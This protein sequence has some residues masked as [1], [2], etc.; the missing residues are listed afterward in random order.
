MANILNYITDCQHENFYETPLN[1]LDILALTEVSYL[2][3]DDLIC[4]DFSAE[5]G[6]RLDDL[7]TQF[8]E[9]FKMGYPPLSMVNRDR[10]ALLQSLSTSKRFKY[11]RAFA[12]INDYS[13]EAQKQFAAVCYRI[14]PQNVLTVFR[15]TDD[16]IIGWKEDFHMTY[17]AE[18]PAQAA[19]RDYLETAIEKLTTNFYVSGHSKGGN[20]AIFASSQVKTALQESIQDVYSF[21][22]PGLHDSILQSN[23]YSAIENRIHSIIP[24]GSIVGMMLETPRNALIVKSTGLGL[25]QHVSFTWEIANR[26]FLPAPSLTTESLQMDQTLK[27]WTASLTPEEL[28]TF[29]DLFFGLFTQAGI[30][31]FSDITVDTPTKLQAL[32]KNR[33]LLTPEENQMFERITHLLIDTRYQIWKDQLQPLPNFDMKKLK[34][35]LP[36]FHQS[37]SKLTEEFSDE[38]NKQK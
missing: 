38:K 9:K 16:T 35:N 10:L 34:I 12:Y 31:R 18:I 19:A 29:F 17:M 32:A 15:G 25:G 33:Q 30:Y 20:L 23:G 37:L 22:G 7:A 2:P 28:K 1:E 14:T 8:H 5:K 4:P 24:E 13:L 21:D 36:D 6:I 3:F 27:T 26:T 11:I